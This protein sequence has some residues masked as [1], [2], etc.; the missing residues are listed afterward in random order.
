MYKLRAR[1]ERG[2]TV[3]DFFKSAHSFSFAQY[4]DPFNM[5]FSDL[6][7]INDDIIAPSGNLGEQTIA[8]MEIITIILD[9]ALQY[10]FSNE[11]TQLLTEGQ[12]QVINTGSGVTF[13][14]FNPS[15]VNNTHLLQ[16]WILP[17]KKNYAPSFQTKNFPRER[18]L[19]RIRMIVSGSGGDGSLKIRQDAEIF[20]SVLEA[21]KTVYFAIPEN[22]KL[23]L[24]VAKGAIEVNSNILE[25]GDG[26]SIVNE[27]GEIEIN[28]VD[29][30]SNF[31]IFN[32]RNLTI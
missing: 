26:M 32:L 19:N 31:L 29:A 3:T 15:P 24:Q 10:K 16:I 14:R 5:G 27:T 30:D 6:R 21:D 8:N 28:G 2:K 22:S 1:E 4:F 13:N 18:L 25:S 9:G 11:K 12:I 17:S 7:V 20:Q 23:W